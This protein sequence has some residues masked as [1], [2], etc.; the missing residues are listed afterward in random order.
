MSF[1]YPTNYNDAL[2]IVTRKGKRVSE[3]SFSRRVS[4]N[5][6][7]NITIEVLNAPIRC[8][9]HGSDVVTWHSDGTAELDHHGWQTVTTKRRMNQCG[10]NVYQSKHEWYIT[11]QAGTFAW[12]DDNRIMIDT[13]GMV[14]WES[15]QAHCIKAA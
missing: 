3:G 15:G 7:F 6:T 13:D 2:D 1:E 4:P 9:Y 14:H 5:T 8:V 10:F 11:T 12:G